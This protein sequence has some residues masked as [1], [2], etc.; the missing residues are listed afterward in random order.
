MPLVLWSEILLL[1]APF[2]IL[3]FA[4]EA[5][6]RESDFT[7]YNCSKKFGILSPHNL[8]GSVNTTND[9]D[10]AK[11][12]EQINSDSIINEILFHQI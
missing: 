7:I 10:Q 8:A 1:D 4:A 11:L 2:S 6:L 12:A 3:S 5:L 9:Q